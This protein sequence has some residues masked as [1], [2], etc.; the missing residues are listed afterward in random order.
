LVS[1]I[2]LIGGGLIDA[3]LDTHAQEVREAIDHV[4][5]PAGSGGFVLNPTPEGS[6]VV[7]IKQAFQLNLKERGW[8]LEAAVFPRGGP[9]KV[10]AAKQTGQHIT[11][12]EWETGNIS[13]SHRA[14][15]KMTLALMSG[16]AHQGL[17]VMPTRAMARYLTD[18]I[19]NLEELAPY[20]PVFKRTDV[21]GRLTILVVQ[22]DRID[23]VVPRI[24]KGTDGRALR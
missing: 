15:N 2:T 18:R 14:L 22:H 1:T 8:T 16:F 17:L 20:F 7:P 21:P 10:D 11:V 12:V 4:E 5:W 24:A 6:G 19:G 3:V 23:A 13:S 9:G